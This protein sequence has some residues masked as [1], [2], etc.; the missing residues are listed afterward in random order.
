M[1]A[2]LP[3]LVGVIHLR[4]L[5]ES[6][7]YDGD[8]AAVAASA[9][10]DA[11]AL[12]I[13]GFDGIVV[14]NFGD[15]PFVPGRVAPVTVAALTACALAVRAAAPGVALGINVLRNDAEA[16][17]AVAVAVGAEMIRVNVHTGA[18]VTDQGLIEGHAHLTLRQRRALGAERVAL[19]CDVD[20]KHSAALAPRPIGE[21]AYDLAARGLADAVLVTGSGTGRGASR[22]DLAAVLAAVH[23][24]V[25]VA[26]GVT[27]ETLADVR[28]AH[29]VIVGSCLRA[30]GKAGGEVD[31]E[32]AKRFAEA[33]RRSRG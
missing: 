6:P 25:L 7:R 13:A 16:A 18:R 1:S 28:E 12:V 15:A 19:L 5:P 23:V 20:V 33:F 10:R 30:G 11:R 9:A 22:E 29:G 8:L 14:E 31:G 4:P 32:V 2:P 3:S 24:P 26:S 27:V 17:L 21:E